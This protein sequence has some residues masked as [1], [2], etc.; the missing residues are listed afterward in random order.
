MLLRDLTSAMW[1]TRLFTSL[2]YSW[3]GGSA[4]GAYAFPGRTIA[5][6]F[7]VDAFMSLVVTLMPKD[8]KTCIPT[9]LNH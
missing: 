3:G 5:L 4:A 6:A 1:F 7:K 8:I 9:H 2:I